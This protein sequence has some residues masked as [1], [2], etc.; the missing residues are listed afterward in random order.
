MLNQLCSP[1]WVMTFTQI[2]VSAW[3]AATGKTNITVNESVQIHVVTEQVS[4]LE[5]LLDERK[6]F[7]SDILKFSL[8]RR[9]NRVIGEQKEQQVLNWYKDLGQ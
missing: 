2:Y 7:K 3:H 6:M 9:E 1:S 5:F 4:S 8:W